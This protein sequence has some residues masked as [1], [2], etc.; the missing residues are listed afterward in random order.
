VSKENE[1]ERR[2]EGERGRDKEEGEGGQW[3]IVLMVRAARIEVLRIR[4]PLHNFPTEVKA[5]WSMPFPLKIL[6][7]VCSHRIYLTN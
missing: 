6:I 7:Q 2:R 3:G 4:G 5:T 1:R